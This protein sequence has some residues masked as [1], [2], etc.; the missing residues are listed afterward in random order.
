MDPSLITKIRTDTNLVNGYQYKT[1]G[2]SKKLKTF[3]FISEIIHVFPCK[4]GIFRI[5]KSQWNS[6]ILTKSAFGQND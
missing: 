6:R 1:Q 2:V 3:L 4:Q 5:V